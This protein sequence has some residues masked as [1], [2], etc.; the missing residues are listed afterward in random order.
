MPDGAV[1]LIVAVDEAGGSEEASEADVLVLLA[2]RRG[3]IRGSVGI[4]GALIAMLWTPSAAALH[5]SVMLLRKSASA[6]S[7]LPRWRASCALYSEY[8]ARSRANGIDSL[9]GN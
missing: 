2:I 8:P 7:L 5:N 9:I 4:A 6:S 1:A 3:L